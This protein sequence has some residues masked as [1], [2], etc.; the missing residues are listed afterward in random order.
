S[1]SEHILDGASRALKKPNWQNRFDIDQIEHRLS[2]IRFLVKLTD[3]VD[4]IHGVAEDDED[5][6]VL[7]TAVAANADFFLMTGDKYGSAS[8]SYG[9]SRSSRRERFPT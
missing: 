8:A 4:D 5:D 7:A 2:R 1:I 9:A 6:L 3:P